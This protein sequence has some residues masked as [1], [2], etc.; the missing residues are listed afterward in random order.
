MQYKQIN[1]FKH[2]VNAFNLAPPI[3]NSTNQRL[4]KRAHLS[5]QY[6][7]DTVTETLSSATLACIAGKQSLA[8]LRKLFYLCVT[9]A[10]TNIQNYG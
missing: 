4:S 1:Q 8:N 7:Q 5:K 2:R 10:L 3:C 9:K 6:P